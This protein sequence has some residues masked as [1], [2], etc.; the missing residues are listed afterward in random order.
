MSIPYYLLY[1]IRLNYPVKVNQELLLIERA[2]RT[3]L[4]RVAL[5]KENQQQLQ[6][7]NQKLKNLLKANGINTKEVSK[8]LEDTI[9]D[10]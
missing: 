1:T 7:E 9:N 6:E 4:Q 8:G 3:L 10:V 2:N 5:L